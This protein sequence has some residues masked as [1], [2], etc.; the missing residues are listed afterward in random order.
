[1]LQLHRAC[2]TWELTKSKQFD[3]ANETGRLKYYILKYKH[4]DLKHTERSQQGWV[5][6]F[7]NDLCMLAG[8]C[9]NSQEWLALCS[10]GVAFLFLLKYQLHCNFAF[11]FQRVFYGS[12]SNNG[13]YVTLQ[14]ANN[15]QQE[16]VFSK[17]IS[18]NTETDFVLISPGT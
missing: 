15:L 5:H 12:S 14:S 11:F 2:L 3:S 7:W 8:L 6:Y 4:T 17:S 16:P 10:Y 1:M 13:Q 18:S 9:L